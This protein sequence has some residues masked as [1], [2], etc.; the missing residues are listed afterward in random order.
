MKGKFLVFSTMMIA[1]IAV[2]SLGGIFLPTAQSASNATCSVP[3][4]SYATIQSA[5]DDPNCAIIQLTASLYRENVTVFR[6]IEVHGLGRDKTVIDGQLL[7]S[8]FKLLI[9][10]AYTLTNMT[11]TNGEKEGAGIYLQ[12][13]TLYL[14]NVN[15]EGNL[16]SSHGSGIFASDGRV[17]L[18]NSSI[19]NNKTTNLDGG[20]IFMRRSEL[21]A[22][23]SQLNGNFSGR[24]GGAIN[25]VSGSIYLTDTQIISNTANSEGA[26]IY[27]NGRLTI[28]GG[29]I[30]Y[31]TSKGYLGFNGRG[32]AIY[33]LS[34]DGGSVI[35]GT[36]FVGNKTIEHG[37]AVYNA[38]TM[39]IS[40]CQFV[41]NEA[42]VIGGAVHNVGTLTITQSTFTQNHGE[43]GG[44]VGNNRGKLT[45][46][47]SEISGN[48]ANSGGGISLNDGQTSIQNTQIISNTALQVGGAIRNIGGLLTIDGSQ[49]L[50]NHLTSSP[51]Y[52]GGIY[53]INSTSYLT[54]TDTAIEDNDAAEGGGLYLD[55]TNAILEEADIHRNV[56]TLGGAG[57]HAENS[58]LQLDRSRLGENSA[59]FDGGGLSLINGVATLRQTEI[60]NNQSNRGAGFYANGTTITVTGGKI[61]GNQS[62]EGAGIYNSGGVVSLQSSSIVQNIATG[63][64][65]GLLNNGNFNS[66]N[67]TIS[68]N[69]ALSGGGIFNNSG[70]VNLS[71]S[72][73]ANNTS[74]RGS[75]LRNLSGS[76]LVNSTIFAGTVVPLCDGT[77][78]SLGFNLAED[79]SCVSADSDITGQSAR[80]DALKTINNLVVHPLLGG[81]P[82]L[83][84]A[85]ST[86]CPSI[87]QIGTLRPFAGGCDIG[88][89]ESAE[90]EVRFGQS[91]YTVN[92]KDGTIDIDVTLN[93]VSAEVVR[94]Q[95]AIQSGAATQNSDYQG[96][97]GSLTFPAGTASQ[98]FSI[99]ILED[100]LV[101][102]DETFTITLSASQN[103][104]LG[105][106][107]VVPVTITDNENPTIS[108]SSPTYLANE[109][110]GSVLI[111]V[112]RTPIF[113]ATS[114]VEYRL[115]AGTALG[116][117][118]FT[119]VT[120]T[121][122]FE[123]NEMTANFIVTI[124]D[125]QLREN[126]ESFTLQL[127]NPVNPQIVSAES[128][129]IIL[130]DDADQGFTVFLPII[131]QDS[132]TGAIPKPQPFPRPN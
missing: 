110:G 51:R 114:S 99:P 22:T 50:N 111:T 69:R 81:S 29:E 31:N 38:S 46:I 88:A 106:P 33:Q 63:N 126:D 23:N 52:G 124:V 125:D 94:V 30:S 85:D 11:M 21:H 58:N 70:E 92:E 10:T 24:Y 61:S 77:I 56:V 25:L 71:Y 66:S 16:T 107:I 48:S 28:R 42:T 83:D 87:D 13:G 3:S 108:F 102:G 1:I 76:A 103:A 130:D 43:F 109:A 36:R 123:P 116:G 95:Y 127:F 8:A 41:D 59:E 105:G 6:N 75:S 112:N 98:K 7:D 14:E 74:I 35:E 40:N 132:P 64:G 100:L 104:R 9:G 90:L 57:I 115:L 131:M 44:A 113:N 120:G 55:D 84:R 80:L 93:T 96:T 17:I 47:D 4:S 49:L 2:L 60:T 122:I 129:F 20:A 27:G 39:V 37:G 97:Q 121:I 54:L 5:V 32:G 118:D 79:E 12:T 19:S 91:S 67:T 128:T 119:L 53:Q 15:I 34:A 73:L 72:T 65:G 82:A 117:S 62:V 78:V 68:G 26:A 89:F 45:L 18:V 101:E 86:L